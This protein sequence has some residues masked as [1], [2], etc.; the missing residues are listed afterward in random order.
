MTDGWSAEQQEETDNSL[1]QEV[2]AIRRAETRP[3][4]FTT[5]RRSRRR[6]ERV[7]KRERGE[8]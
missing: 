5:L 8:R 3:Y 7:R 6:S 1:W 4:L 2:K